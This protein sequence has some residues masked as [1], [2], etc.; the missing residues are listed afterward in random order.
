V[1]RQAHRGSWPGPAEGPA[2]PSRR[3]PAGPPGGSRQAH[4]GGSA[5][6]PGCPVG[7]PRGCPQAV[8]GTVRR[9]TRGTSQTPAGAPSPT[10]A[11]RADRTHRPAR[12]P[13]RVPPAGPPPA[14]PG[15]RDP[16]RGGRGDRPGGAD[17]KGWRGR[18]S[19]RAPAPNYARGIGRRGRIPDVAGESEILRRDK[20]ARPGRS[21]G[22]SGQVSRANRS[23]RTRAG[24]RVP[25]DQ[26]QPAN[27][28]GPGPAGQ[29]QRT[30]AS[31]PMPAD[32][33]QPANA[34]RPSWS[35]P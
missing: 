9:P 2:A 1:A 32:Q 24:W 18:S 15:V 34:G 10:P 19:P 13:S 35:T 30:R 26:G 16:A 20:A 14:P 3:V 29:C 11:G 27:A 4:P 25:A 28:S 33:G 6:L 17:F 22:L 21:A 7:H 12:G 31:R 5:G 8:R 23:R